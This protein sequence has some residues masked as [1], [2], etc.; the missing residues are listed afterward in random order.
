MVDAGGGHRNAANALVA[1]SEEMKTPWRFKVENLQRVLE[2]LDFYKRITGLT[3][4]DAYN[5]LLRRRWTAYMVPM[6]R[7]MQSFIRLMHRPL[8]ARLSAHLRTGRPAA[9]V[10]VMPNFNAVLRDAVHDCFPGVPFVVLLT[11]LADFPPGFWVV[12]GVERVIAGSERAVAQARETGVPA[13]RISRTSGM[14]LHPRF[15]TRGGPDARVRVRDELGIGADEFVLMLLFGGKGSAEMRPLCERLLS[16]P[17][18]WRVIAICGDNPPLLA[19]LTGLAAGA[20]GRL[21]PIGFTD[22]VV[23]YMAASDVLLTKPGPGSLAEA[24]HQKVPVVVTCNRH[25]IPQ[26]RY[27]TRFVEEHGVGIVVAHWREMPAAAATLAASPER[28]RELRGNL[29]RLPENRAVYEAIEI[30]GREVLTA[31]PSPAPSPR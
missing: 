24:W 12:P 25:T 26:E 19:S 28:R 8:C 27:N 21:H 20:G 6:L 17:E 3:L 13:E 15:Y 9:V 5:L 22:R 14:V 7:L 18:P 30:I 23:D 10:S 29:D 4:E 2:P 11:D 16:R 31:T 1:A